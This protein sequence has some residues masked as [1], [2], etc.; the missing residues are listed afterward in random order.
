MYFGAI[1][2]LISD[3]IFIWLVIWS[4]IQNMIENLGESVKFTQKLTN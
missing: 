1:V 4:G 3:E 2:K